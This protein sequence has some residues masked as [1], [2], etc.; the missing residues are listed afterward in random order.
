M[1][2]KFGEKMGTIYYD[3]LGYNITLHRERGNTCLGMWK[4]DNT[5]GRWAQ[6][7]IDFKHRIFQY[8]LIIVVDVV[9]VKCVKHDKKCHG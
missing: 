4:Q 2:P 3:E 6:I 8:V 9:Q 5:M 7:C 1:I